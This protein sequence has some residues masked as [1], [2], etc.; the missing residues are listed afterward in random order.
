MKI[1][2]ATLTLISSLTLLFGAQKE[3]LVSQDILSITYPYAKKMVMDRLQ[4]NKLTF[5]VSPEQIPAQTASAFTET[6]QR[7]YYRVLLSLLSDAGDFLNSLKLDEFNDANKKQIMAYMA[8]LQMK[9][10]HS[11]IMQAKGIIEADYPQD[12]MFALQQ[13][14]IDFLTS[15]I[16]IGTLVRHPMPMERQ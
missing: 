11:I 15:A 13:E 14:T 9:F 3:T 5:A 4:A 12:Q 7:K 6:D 2:I 10:N 1:I 16:A 8:D